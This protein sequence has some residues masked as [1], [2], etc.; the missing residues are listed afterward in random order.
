MSI[1]FHHVFAAALVLVAA[2]ALPIPAASRADDPMPSPLASQEHA[3]PSAGGLS[4]R[5]TLRRQQDASQTLRGQAGGWVTIMSEGFEQA[6][7]SA[8]WEE[9]PGD[10]H[11]GATG[12]KAYQGNRSA[13]CAAGGASG[14]DPRS[15]DYPNDLV[16]FMVYGPFD[17]SNGQDAELTFQA[18]YETEADFDYLQVQVSR[19][20]ET[21]GGWPGIS[22][23]SEGAWYGFR[24]H[25]DDAPDVGQL[26]GDP[27][28]WIAIGFVSD[29]RVTNAGAFV[30][31]IVLRKQLV[32]RPFSLYLPIV[33]RKAKVGPAK[34]LWDEAHNEDMTLSWERAQ[35]LVPEHPDWVYCGRLVA[36]L[37]DEFTVVR[38]ATAPFTSSFLAGYDAVILPSPQSGLTQA[39]I[40]ALQQFMQGGGGVLWLAGSEWISEPILADK[41]IDLDSHVLRDSV[42]DDADFDVTTF[43]SHPA[44]AGVSRVV[45][46]WGGSLSVAAPSAALATTLDR[47]Y[48]DVNGN[49]R[50]DAGER[51]GP[52]DIAAAYES[53]AVRL[54]VVSGLPFQD[55]GYDGRNN[56][57]FMRALLRWLTAAR[58]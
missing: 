32:D 5:S 40:L 35:T 8:G 54:V 53:G 58:S 43:A 29:S 37:E 1:R 52:F 48:Q 28:V 25:L 50:R 57:P 36:D 4:L 13:W 27:S 23:S 55:S 14:L 3:R 33:T 44:V 19:D 20:R 16:T 15:S 34:V 18:W 30:D 38:N 11:W 31:D 17:L 41:G 49:Q 47:V 6:W 46:N 56:T 21:W 12:F 24:Y 42:N 45:T 22:G 51:M 9:M 7:P 2:W 39:E 26:L 10:P